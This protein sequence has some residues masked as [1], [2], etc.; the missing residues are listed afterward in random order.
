MSKKIILF[1]FA[2][3]LLIL[4][5]ISATWNCINPDVNEYNTNL[6]CKY[7]A[8]K[9]ET[10][11]PKVFNND[12]LVYSYNQSPIEMKTNTPYSLIIKI[13]V[14]KSKEGKHKIILIQNNE[15]YEQI[16]SIKRITKDIDYNINIDYTKSAISNSVFI[17]LIL[18]NNTNKSISTI[19]KLNNISNNLE[20][21]TENK[22]IILKAN[23]TK[24]IPIKINYDNLDT[25]MNLNYNLIYGNNI[26]NINIDLNKEELNFISKPN[27][28][29]ALFMFAEKNSNTALITLNVI[30]FICAIVL[31]TMFVGRLGKYIIKK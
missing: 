27:T 3:I 31:F 6:V 20:S 2:L 22:I 30:L 9:Q 26:Q 17:D 28:I 1:V 4:P 29:T 18:K 21:D 8:Y 24:I 15:R 11:Y 7:T 16:I 19:L 23:E 13:D 25:N 10:F 12:G 5:S 14:F